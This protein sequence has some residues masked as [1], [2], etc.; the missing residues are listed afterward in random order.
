MGKKFKKL[1][2]YEKSSTCRQDSILKTDTNA[3]CLH[4]I[5]ITLIMFQVENPDGTFMSMGIY[6]LEKRANYETIDV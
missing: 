1:M 2:G 5:K 4:P 6:K 3:N